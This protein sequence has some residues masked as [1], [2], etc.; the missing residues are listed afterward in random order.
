[1]SD[2]ALTE[3]R[4]GVRAIVSAVAGVASRVDKLAAMGILPGVELL[5]HQKTPV[6][7]IE[8]GETVLAVEHELARDIRV[9][10]CEPAAS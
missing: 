3:L 6:V 9:A 4:A 1:V 7:V 5:V 8:C 2:I 10:P